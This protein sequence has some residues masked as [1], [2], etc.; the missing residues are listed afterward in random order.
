MTIEMLGPTRPAAT[1]P[2]FASLYAEVQRFYDHQMRLFDAEETQHTAGS[3]TGQRHWIGMLEAR[4]QPDG[5]VLTK[6]SALVSTAAADGGQKGLHVRVL[7]D[8]LVRCAETNAWTLRH[9][10]VTRDNRV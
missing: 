9:R 3:G 5:T 7:E 6:C 10:T 2:A 1:G 8:V 4:P